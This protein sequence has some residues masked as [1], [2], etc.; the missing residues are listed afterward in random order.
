MF[1]ATK[2]FTNSTNRLSSDLQGKENKQKLLGDT[3]PCLQLN[4]VFFMVVDNK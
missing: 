4:N 3:E 1:F 2:H